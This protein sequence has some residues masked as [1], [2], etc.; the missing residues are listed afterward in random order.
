MNGKMG[1][2]TD[3]VKECVDQVIK[4]LGNDIKASFPL[5]LGKPMLF[6]DELYRRA[7]ENPEIRLVIMTALTLEIPK[8]KTDLE[9][10]ILKPIVDRIFHG[11]KDF[12]F[13]IDY[14]N[15]NLPANVTFTEMYSKAGSILND[16]QAQMNHVASNYS[17]AVRDGVDNGA[18]IF[19]QMLSSYGGSFSMGCNTDLGVDA[20]KVYHQRRKN[21]EKCVTIGEVNTNLPFMYS[22]AIV[23][24]MDYD[25]ILKGEQFNMPL[26]GAPKDPITLRDYMIGLNVSTLIK[27]GGTIQVGIGAL[28]DAIVFGLILRNEHNDLYRELIEK[29]GLTTRYRSI[30]EKWG[31][32]GEFKKGL[33]GSSEMLIDGFLQL[34][35]NKILKRKVYDSIPLMKLI[36]DDELSP[37]NIPEDII[38]KLL[39]IKAI[40]KILDEDDFNFL[41]KFG[42]I[43]NSVTMEGGALRDGDETYS[44]D[45][46]NETDILKI[47]KILGKKLLGGEII[48]GAFYIGPQSFYRELNEMPE[49]ERMQFGMSGVEKV[50]QLYGGEELRRLQRRD[51][52]FV[53]TGMNASVL[54]S[55][56]SDLLPD[57]RVVSGIGGQ[58][59]FAAM[60]H[61][62]QDGRLIMMIKSVKGSGKSLKSNIVFN[63]PQCSV[64]R[65]LRDIIITEYGIADVRGKKDHEVIAE[66][67]NIADSRFQK[68]LL[69]QAKKAKKISMDYEI[70]KEYR[71][72]TP[73]KIDKLLKPYRDMGHFKVFPFGTD[74]KK[75]EFVLAAAM[76]E[77]KSTAAEKPFK[78]LRGLLLETVRSVPEAASVYLKHMD[79]E[80]PATLKERIGRNLVLVGLR[81]SRAI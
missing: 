68:Q 69:D 21:G 20:L 27:D 41:K 29:A 25:F 76:K 5:G 57:G 73:E 34:Y 48:C 67:I 45:L 3:D 63:Y 35:K 43:K 46:G 11:V 32:T 50:N 80:K 18:N 79:L 9:K 22:D 13:M 60:A 81:N 36:N 7:K 4:Y 59:D 61:A 55:V 19:G 66:M 12:D 71:N 16:S 39:K 54:G 14:R 78:L 51:G 33:Y 28:G 30:I 70:P 23:D 53:N 65:H 24:K 17:H 56:S 8:G 31:D 44:T 38:E 75:E 40:N 26:F 58:Y 15:G 52:R 10:R 2:I 74:F 62:L 37:D 49:E 6:I 77:L 47:R 42:I 72:N 64:P 1:V